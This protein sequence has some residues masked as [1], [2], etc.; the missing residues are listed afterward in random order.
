MDKSYLRKPLRGPVSSL[1]SSAALYE[2]SLIMRLARKRF[3]LK[4]SPFIKGG[5]SP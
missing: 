2:N 1:R 4:N 5:R 3:I